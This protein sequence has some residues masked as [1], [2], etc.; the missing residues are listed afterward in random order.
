MRIKYAILLLAFP[1]L[2]FAAGQYTPAQIRTAVRQASPEGFVRAL[3]SNVAKMAGQM[4]D[5]Q[6]QITGAAAND[7]T[8]VNYL[9]LV[10]YDKSE[11]ASVP[12]RRQQVATTLA[13]AVCTAPVAS[14]LINEFGGEYKYM[15]YSKSREYLFE[16][17]FNKTTCSS[18]YRW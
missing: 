10:N 11:I 15:A 14:I 5:D 13:P 4:L 18:N 2:C 8:L 6:T 7:R 12:L 1:V 17:A 9:R 16:Y 3:A